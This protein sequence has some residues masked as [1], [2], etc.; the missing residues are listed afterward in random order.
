MDESKLSGRVLVGDTETT[1][2]SSEY[3][4][5]TE[6]AL[7]EVINFEPTG[8]YFHTYLFSGKKIP[9]VVRE[10]TGIT[11]EFLIG[12]PTFKAISGGLIDFVG[13]STIVAHN[14][15]FDMN[16]I[17][18]ELIRCGVSGI[19]ESQFFDTL[20]MAR[21]KYVGKKNSLDQICKRMKI[22]LDSRDQHGAMIDS[23]LLAKVF[24][25]M[26]KGES[27]LFTQEELSKEKEVSKP[28]MGYYVRER[29]SKIPNRMTDIQKSK[30]RK[31][32]KDLEDELGVDMIWNRV[33]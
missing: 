31:F 24:K 1:G 30:H 29:P 20:K 10:L 18:S 12:K 15:N 3:D 19:N 21:E 27:L 7:I 23:I 25:N 8:K 32:I 4:R 13:D 28:L 6:I 11:N 22:S 33:R 26:C 5:I 16:F 9:V 17:N 2:L 14:A